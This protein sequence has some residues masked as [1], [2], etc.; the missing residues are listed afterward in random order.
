[1]AAVPHAGFVGGYGETTHEDPLMV[2]IPGENFV[3]IG[4]ATLKLCLNF[5][6][7][8][9]DSPTHGPKISFLGFG[10]QDLGNIIYAPKRHSFLFPAAGQDASKMSLFLAK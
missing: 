1:M 6:S 2:A 5:L 8:T 4:I 10:Y 3:M 9:L 7:F